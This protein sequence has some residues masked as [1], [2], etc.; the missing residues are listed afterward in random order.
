MEAG[1]H[2]SSHANPTFSHFFTCDLLFAIVSFFH[3]W[4]IIGTCGTRNSLKAHRVILL[5]WLYCQRW[6]QKQ[7]SISPSCQESNL[8]GRWLESLCCFVPTGATRPQGQTVTTDCYSCGL[9]F[10]SSFRLFLWQSVVNDSVVL[11]SV[12][13][14]PAP[15]F[16]LHIGRGSCPLFVLLVSL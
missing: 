6:P 3:M 16:L 4:F 8:I 12:G 10:K 11:F 9:S 15:W 7:Q 2:R 14:V 5:L 13:A 1:L